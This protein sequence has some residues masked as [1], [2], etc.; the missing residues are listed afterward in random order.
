MAKRKKKTVFKKFS[1][2]GAQPST[3]TASGA[4]EGGDEQLQQPDSASGAPAVPVEHTASVGECLH[5]ALGG[6]TGRK[7]ANP[8]TDSLDSFVLIRVRGFC[9]HHPMVE[10]GGLSEDGGFC[11]FANLLAR[12]WTLVGVRCIRWS[13]PPGRGTAHRAPRRCGTSL[14]R[15]GTA[16]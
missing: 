15:F 5:G 11:D 3:Q 9:L 12:R 14:G 8:T 13:C 2:V 4:G 16:P 10:S 1:E 7:P 6:Q